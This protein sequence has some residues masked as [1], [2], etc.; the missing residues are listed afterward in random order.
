MILIRPLLTEK[1]YKQA[2]DF[3][4]Y[5]F[6]VAVDASKVEIERAVEKKFN[7]NV[8]EISTVNRLG[9]LKTFGAKRTRG[10]RSNTKKAIVKLKDKQTIDLFEMK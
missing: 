6:E 3:N 2:H 8:T 4:Q 10:T 7:V 5:T 1:T 9:K